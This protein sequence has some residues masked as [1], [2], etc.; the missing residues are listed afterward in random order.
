M[1]LIISFFFL[2]Y[3]KKMNQPVWMHDFDTYHVD[4]PISI[5][6]SIRFYEYFRVLII[7]LH[8][9]TFKLLA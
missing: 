3:P 7:C 9:I 4:I 6:K 2:A 1:T 8:M 5:I